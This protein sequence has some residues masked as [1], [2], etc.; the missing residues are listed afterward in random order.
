MDKKKTSFIFGS[1]GEYDPGPSMPSATATSSRWARG[2]GQL[3][4]TT[5]QV[6]F[7]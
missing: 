7:C 6:Y 5:P 4:E 1:R 2:L 3:K